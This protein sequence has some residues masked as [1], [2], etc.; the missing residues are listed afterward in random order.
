MGILLADLVADLQADV[1]AVDGVPSADQYSRAIKAA[2]ADFSRRCGTEK[3]AT[4]TI[5]SGTATYSLED[6]F[7]KLIVLESFAT[8]DGVLITGEGIIPLDTTWE[9]R[10]YIRNRQITFDPT[11]TYNMARDYRYK[12]AW[13]LN[14][15][16]DEYEE[17][18]DEEADIILLR[19]AG[20]CLTRQANTMSPDAMDYQQGDVKVSTGTQTLAVRAQVDALQKQYI[21]ACEQ[22][23]SHYGVL[24]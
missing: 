7:L 21:E 14:G 10:W 4:L 22:Y 5:V 24:G 17:L 18:G 9:E 19:A 1:P 12:A 6:D 23:N 11:P 13:I 15:D 20:S 2:A 8:A 16:G 3:I